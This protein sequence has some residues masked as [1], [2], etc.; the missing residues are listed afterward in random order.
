[1]DKNIVKIINE[2]ISE[3]DFLG[4]DKYLK[5]EENSLLLKNEDF[6]KQ[7]IS[8]ILTRKTD[9]I[10]IK[11]FDSQITGDFNNLSNDENQINIYYVLN[12]DYNYDQSKEPVS[13][14]LKFTGNN[15]STSKNI[16][17]GQNNDWL[18]YINWNDVQVSL[19]GPNGVNVE[20]KSFKKSSQKIQELFIR[21]F[22]DECT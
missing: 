20:F 8:D 9:K 22:L 3:Y 1:M 4:N 19:L 15:I 14:Y 21:E 10:K 13:F 16:S 12:V 11:I 17:Q 18:N 7:F 5:E 2:V 6:Q